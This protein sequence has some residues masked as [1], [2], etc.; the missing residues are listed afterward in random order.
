MNS[1]I[2]A[3]LFVNSSNQK[4]LSNEFIRFLGREEIAC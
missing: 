1:Y 4:F 2:S 3:I